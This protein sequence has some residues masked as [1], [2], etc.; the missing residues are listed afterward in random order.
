MIFNNTRATFTTFVDTLLP[1][2]SSPYEQMEPEGKHDSDALSAATQSSPYITVIREIDTDLQ[3]TKD[4]I[5]SKLSEK[6]ANNFQ[7]R[8]NY[9]IFNSKR[10]D[11]QTIRVIAQ[12]HEIVCAKFKE[13]STAPINA[14]LDQMARRIEIVGKDPATELSKLVPELGVEYMG[15]RNRFKLCLGLTGSEYECDLS[16]ELINP[17]SFKSSFDTSGDA[18]REMYEKTATEMFGGISIGE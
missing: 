17:M 8:S 12:T 14:R 6:L 18:N 13:E 1:D 5:T 2:I 16:P 11:D 15:G 9:T 4:R 10:T 7:Y 3:K